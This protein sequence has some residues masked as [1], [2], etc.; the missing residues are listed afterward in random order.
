MANDDLHPEEGKVEEGKK[1]FSDR[2]ELR[3]SKDKLEAL[4]VPK[5]DNKAG[6]QE[7][8]LEAL[9]EKLQRDSIE[10]G[11]LPE[12]E[13]LKDGSFCVARGK[14]PE[15]GKDAIIRPHVRPVL[16]RTP[17]KASEKGRVDHRELGNISNVSKEML[18]LEKIPAAEG[19]PGKSVQGFDLPA[20]PGKDVKL[21]LGSGIYL[22]D[23]GLRV[24]AQVNGKFVLADGKASVFEE[25]V[26]RGDVDMSVGNIAFGGETLTV[27][28]SVLPGFQ[29]K[30]RGAI[31]IAKGVNDAVVMAGANLHIRGGIVADGAKALAKGDVSVDFAE[32]INT[33]EAGG[34][35][36]LADFVVQGRHMRVGKDFKAVQ[37]KGL[38]VGG[39][40]LIGGSMHVK[41]LGSDAGVETKITVGI[42]KNFEAHKA[43]NESDLALWSERLNNT[44]KNVN[45]L[46]KM[47]KEPD[48]VLD[49]DKAR[50]LKKMKGAMPKL[51]EKVNELQEEAAAIEEEIERRVTECVY[52]YEKIHSGV[53]IRIGPVAR[54]INDPEEQVV[55]YFDPGT[56]AIKLRKLKPEELAAMDSLV[57]KTKKADE[58][59]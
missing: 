43:Q 1:D 17:K 32:N 40:S 20:K 52:V 58:E 44:L 10:F 38:V 33:L 7:G 19:V 2:F 36:V 55:A 37:G 4:L 25:H 42:D 11:I 24:Y 27:D 8:D 39:E 59:D 31:S 14:L 35:L 26:V 15:T 3:I 5:A 29:L 23:D 46:E 56:R 50:L 6:L 51:M 41:Q 30:C 21:K 12:P 22:S 34:E 45:S 9:K 16:A 28:G 49:D 53:S 48:A 47:Q 57:D 13:S 18:L 54:V